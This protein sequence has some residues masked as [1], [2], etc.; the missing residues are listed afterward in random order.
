MKNVSIIGMGLIGGSLGMALKKRARGKYHV[1]A[2]GR[3]PKKLKHAKKIKAADVVTIDMAGGV[4]GA[5]IIVICTP[6]DLIAATVKKILPFVKQGAVI[7]DAGSVKGAVLNDV[8]KVFLSAKR[9]SL[10]A[11]FVGAHPMAGSEKYGIKAARSDLYNGASVVIT[12]D[13]K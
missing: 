13:K 7:T 6:V 12:P 8:K 3:N 1:T 11:N 5:D 4:K 9:Y 10:Y 2:V